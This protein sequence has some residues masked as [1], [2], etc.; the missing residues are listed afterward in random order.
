MPAGIRWRPTYVGI[1]TVTLHT[2]ACVVRAELSPGGSNCSLVLSDSATT[3]NAVDRRVRLT[4]HTR[5]QKAL[6]VETQFYTGISVTVSGAN[7]AA[8]VF[9]KK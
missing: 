9:V 1:G 5:D 7:A 4:S 2:G 3:A 6:S 8:V